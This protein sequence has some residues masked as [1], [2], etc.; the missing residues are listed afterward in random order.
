ME[1]INKGNKAIKISVD[2]K[3]IK[4][5]WKVSDLPLDY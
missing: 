3:Q 5:E 4:K 2:I 1:I